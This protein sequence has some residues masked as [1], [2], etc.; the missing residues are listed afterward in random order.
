MRIRSATINYLAIGLWVFFSML[1]HSLYANIIPKYIFVAVQMFVIL[2]SI[3]RRLKYSFSRHSILICFIITLCGIFNIVMSGKYSLYI[4]IIVLIGAQG[5]EFKKILKVCLYSVGFCMLFVVLSCKMGI[6]EDYIFYRYGAER[7]ALGFA[8]CYLSSFFLNWTMLFL[9]TKGSQTKLWHYA[10]LI[11]INQ[12][13]Y[14]VSN[15]RGIYYILI[16][17]VV[18]HFFFIRYKERKCNF[19]IHNYFSMLIYPI[20]CLGSYIVSFAYRSDTMIWN[21][22]DHFF[23]GRL[24]FM[25]QAINTYGISLFGEKIELVG[26]QYGVDKISDYVDNAYLQIGLEYGIVILILI[27]IGYSFIT[28]LAVKS[29]DSMLYVWLILISIQSL[30]YPTLISIINNSAVLTLC[31]LFS[32][33]Y[34]IL[35]LMNERIGFNET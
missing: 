34:K 4:L 20:C 28:Y 10:M 33:N 32:N 5:L 29:H 16:F 15:V 11:V 22:M 3:F 1:T 26:N 21:V 13:L 6:I 14:N 19:K 35:P 24:A 27:V 12:V 2:V 7:H 17:V 31:I 9:Y 25:N 30:V 18:I 23:T 8:Y